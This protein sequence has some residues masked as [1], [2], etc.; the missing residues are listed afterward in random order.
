MNG[1]TGSPGDA[2]RNADEVLVPVLVKE[3]EGFIADME[4]MCAKER[5][6]APSRAEDPDPGGPRPEPRAVAAISPPREGLAP[7][8]DRITRIDV[9]V[10]L[11]Y[12]L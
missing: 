3:V 12:R 7:G 11:G 6:G 5:D 10:G 1:G 8:I 2:E 9:L 4:A